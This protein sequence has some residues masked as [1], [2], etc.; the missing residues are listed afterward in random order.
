[1]KKRTL[2]AALLALVLAAAAVGLVACGTNTSAASYYLTG[3]STSWATYNKANEIPSAVKFE[4]GGDSLYTLTVSL[5]EDDVFQ[6]R[7]AG[8]D[9]VIGYSNLISTREELTEGADNKIVVSKSGSY[10]FSL[11]VSGEAST[12]TYSYT[13]SENPPEDKTVEYVTIQN[14]VELLAVDGTYTFTATV[15]YTDGSEDSA[16]TW[17]SSDATIATVDS[18]TGLVTALKVGETTIT[19]T[20]GDKSDDVLLTVS[21]TVAVT[22]VSLDKETL[23]LEIGASETL[24]ATVVP[25]SASNKALVW[26]SSSPSVATVDSNGVVKA[27]ASGETTITVTTVDG[28]H[29]ADCTVKVVRKVTGISVDET[30]T[31]NEGGNG[32]LTVSIA[33]ANATNTAYTYEVTSGSDK[34]TV[35]DDENGTLTVTGVAFGEAVITVKS[36]ENDQFTATCTVTVVDAS[37]VIVTLTPTATVTK[38]G[39]ATLTVAATNAEVTEVSWTS[40]TESIAT[41]SGSGTTA[42]VTGKD[43]GSTTITANVTTDAGTFTKTCSVLVTD[44]FYYL[45]GANWLDKEGHWAVYDTDAEAAAAGVLLTQ[46]S[47]GVYAITRD[48]TTSDTFHICSDLGW[49]AE[50]KADG[51]FNSED[52]TEYASLVGNKDNVGVAYNGNYT[53]TFDF[54]KGTPKIK[55][56]MN[57]IAVT[58]LTIDYSGEAA[59]NSGDTATLTANVTPTATTFT[60]YE[61]KIVSG[62][63]YASINPNGKTCVVTVTNEPESGS[64]NVEISCTIG[65]VTKTVKVIVMKEGTTQTL[66]SEVTF[67]T[68][69]KYEI[70]VSQSKSGQVTAQ[71][72]ANA[73][74]REVTYSTEDSGITIDPDTGAITASKLGTFTVKATAK[75]GSGKF[76]TC[77]VLVYASKMI[78]FGGTNGWDTTGNT[79]LTPVTNGDNS[80]WTTS[81][82]TDSN[83]VYKFIIELGLNGG[84]PAWSDDD[85][86][87]QANT[88]NDISEDGNAGTNASNNPPCYTIKGANRVHHIT[89]DVSGTTPK[90]IIVDGGVIVKTVTVTIGS[91]VIQ[92]GT[93]TTLTATVNPEDATYE[94][95]DITWAVT[96]GSG[97]LSATTGASVTLTAGSTEETI[98]V[99]CTV[100]GVSSTPAN[101]VVSN[102]NTAV[103][104]ITF[105]SSETNTATL[106]IDL[107]KGTTGTVPAFTISPSNAVNQ[108]VTYSSNS[109]KLTVDANGNITASSIGTFTVTLTAADGS[110]VEATCTVTVWSSN[111]NVNGSV[112]GNWTNNGATASL[113]GSTITI[114]YNY[115][116]G[117]NW[118]K[119]ALIY[120]VGGNATDWANHLNHADMGIPDDVTSGCFGVDGGNW[121]MTKPGSETSDATCTI[122]ID[123]SGTTPTVTSMKMS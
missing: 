116:S 33:P 114:T 86:L 39:T 40:E 67:S 98:T 3:E 13:G 31:V 53:V 28:G 102:S 106:T 91:G 110:G 123:I 83:S 25:A 49:S 87:T 11:Y 21:D 81:V 118:F 63:N 93:S 7:K 105:D 6:I 32:T 23:T 96:S 5:T 115:T 51:R 54:T 69:A 101:V 70:D 92:P 100:K 14:Y 55:V 1:M 72:D 76:A 8:A 37:S 12:V 121:Y 27:V 48:L 79:N 60:E 15:S 20:N 66:V 74:N 19:A 89:V 77:T 120:G 35:S 50:F 75:D 109:D 90:I 112:S 108:N 119:F 61:W 42:T 4:S 47:R 78:V 59:L 9:D 94:E 107:D 97:T 113:S 44:S 29:S 117:W 56:T 58:N 22:G 103:E 30:L 73:D 122:T 68:G 82:T 24:T 46:T 34:I 99:Q 95:S 2:L 88:E 111:W 38:N 16:V 52:S 85:N 80:K 45:V 65:G 17:S 43:Y 84:N 26:T 57:S 18:A 41:V 10:T 64:V 71:G 36:A 62:G 104:S